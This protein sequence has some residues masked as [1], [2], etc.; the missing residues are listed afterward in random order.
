MNRYAQS[1]SFT[2]MS[3]YIFLLV[4]VDLI[5]RGIALYKSAQ[6][7]QTYWFVA[8]LVINSVGI[9]PLIYLLLNKDLA[10][11]TAG[12]STVKKT[13]KKTRR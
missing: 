13:G 11:L 5:L 1:M 10:F 12:K 3:P 8:L 6:R 7:S 2:S 4:A 9:L